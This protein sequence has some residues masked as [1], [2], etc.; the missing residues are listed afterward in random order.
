MENIFFKYG[1]IIVGAVVITLLI[2][3][4]FNSLNKTIQ[5][6]YE[7]EQHLSGNSNQL[8]KKLV[9][10]CEY[11]I[12]QNQNKD[13]FVVDIYLESGTLYKSDFNI[14]TVNL[15][16]TIEQGDSTVKIRNSNNMCSIAKL[17]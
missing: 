13:C 7:A 14:D 1:L 2:S 6:S 4:A 16:E 9:E 15:D 17:K 3:F 11:C 12:N 8:N 5:P 10:L